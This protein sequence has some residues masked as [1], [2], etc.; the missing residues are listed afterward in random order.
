MCIHIHTFIHTYIKGPYGYHIISY[1][2]VV[3]YRTVDDIHSIAQH[4]LSVARAGHSQTFREL[5]RLI[6]AIGVMAGTT[7]IQYIHTYMHALL[8][9][10]AQL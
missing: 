1:Y 6:E 5:K 7:Y 9:Y 8:A 4:E 3:E 10:F 2:P